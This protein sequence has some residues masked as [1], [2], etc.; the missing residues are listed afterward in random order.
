MQSE[1]KLLDEELKRLQDE[2]ARLEKEYFLKILTDCDDF[3]NMNAKN[4]EVEKW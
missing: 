3:P 4:V 2:N 1:I